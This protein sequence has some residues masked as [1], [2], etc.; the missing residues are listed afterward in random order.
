MIL[1]ALEESHGNRSYAAQ[2]V[3]ISRRTL[4]RRLRQ[5]GIAESAAGDDISR[6]LAALA[7]AT[8]HTAVVRRD[9]TTAR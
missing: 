7:L 6:N 4:S 8:A 3:G 9:E 1:E 5:Y 2:R